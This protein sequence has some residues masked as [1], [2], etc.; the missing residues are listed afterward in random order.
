[1]NVMEK[2]AWQVVCLVVHGF[3]DK[4]NS[5]TYKELVEILLSSTAYCVVECL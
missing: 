1:M 2:K 5:K 3:L 4:N